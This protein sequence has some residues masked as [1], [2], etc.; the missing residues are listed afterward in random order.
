[1]KFA[2]A[3]IQFGLPLGLAAALLASN[4]LNAA[5]RNWDGDTSTAWATA[6]NWDTAPLNNLTSDIANFNLATYGGNPVYSPSAG[7][8]SIA[9]ISVGS[10]NGNMTITTSALSI[11]ASGITVANGAGTVTIGSTRLGAD[12]SWTNDSSSLLTVTNFSNIGN[13]TPFTV[14]FNGSGSGGTTISGNI[15]DGG[16]TGTTA[17]NINTTGGATTLSGTANAFT[18]G[19]TLTQ[20]TLKLG[21]NAALGGAGNVFTIAGGV[22]DV[23]GA[24][25]TTNNNAQNW[26]GDFIFTGTST[27]NTG[28]G[29][30][31][32]G[33]S[34]QVTVSASTMTVGGAI[35]QAASG[36]TL[37]KL[38]GGT[39]VL[40]GNNSYSGLTTISNGTLTL[41]GNNSGAG[42][43]T[44]SA[45]TL[46]INNAGA[47]GT[48]TFTIGSGTT[49]NSATAIVNSN[50]NAQNWNGSFTFTGTNSL[51]L[52]TGT[53]ALAGPLTVTTTA[54][55][56]TFGGAI[57]GGS[58]FDITKAGAG[59]LAYTGNT[60]M[61]SNRTVN[62]SAGTLAL[63]G[64]IS[65]GFG[66]TVNGAGTLSLSGATANA[67]G[68]AIIINSGNSLTFDSS[69]S[70]VTGTT[71]A[72]SVTLKGATLNVIGNPGASSIDT[73]T[74]ALTATV[75]STFGSFGAST[76]SLTAD[77]AANTR[78]SAGSL[79][80]ANNGAIFFRGINL[81]ANTIASNTAGSS[82]IEFSSA[83]T[84]QLVGGGGAANSQTISI[85]PW[86]VGATT[87]GG[88][89]SS[90]VTYDANGIRPLIVGE[91]ATTITGGTTTSNNIK[92]D[93][94]SLTTN[95]ATL[96]TANGATTVN[97]LF[98]TN[99]TIS[100]QGTSATILAGTGA[101]T[102]TSGA[103]YIDFANGGNNN[104]TVISK[105]VDFGAAEGVIGTLGTSFSKVLSFTGGISGTGG[106]T[107][108]DTNAASSTQAGVSIGAATTYTGNTIINGSLIAANA[109]AL[110]N[111]T[112]GRTGDIYVYG[113]LGVN[114]SVR[115]N[116]L[117]G[118]GRVANP[119]STFRTLTVGDN[120]ATSTF[121][122]TFTTSN[123]NLIKMGT[124]T[125]TLSGTNSSYVGATTIQNG[126]ISVVT[127]NSVSTPSQALTSTLGKPNSSANGTILLGNLTTTGTLKV[128]GTGET[129][130]RIIS[131]AGRTGGGTLDQSGT[132][133]LLF[134]SDVA[135]AGVA[136]TDQRKTL[137]LQGSSLGTGEI[138]GV[139]SDSL[140]G[141]TG[142]KAT[143]LTKS[144]SGT[145]TLS[146][147]NT[148]TG[149]TTV[150]AGK[151]VINGNISTSL[152]TTV[153]N[154]ATLGGN[155]TVG[156]TN[157]ENGGTIA[158][159]SSAG[160]LTLTNG[161]T[162]AGTYD[163]EL[164]TLS[165]A[166]PGTNFDLITLTAGNVDLTGAE[167][168][169]NLGSNAPT[170][171]A[172][173]Q[174]TQTWSGIINNTGAGSL[175]GAF[176]A[177]DNSAWSSLGSFST[178]NSGNDVNLI[179]TAVPEPAP[180]ALLGG[181]GILTLLRRRRGQ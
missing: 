91:Y 60:T 47:L 152:T 161:L 49:I 175:T 90:F 131:L 79:V 174:T 68:S 134:T 179:W 135:A 1:M 171:I 154:T 35:G 111:F 140:L 23:T 21:A 83:P 139:I 114:D 109:N 29:A 84:A 26:N 116:G 42:G 31:T 46:N 106:L 157:V 150:E 87:A 76:V 55:T 40:N 6:G 54:S 89:P 119:F 39:L 110:P 100:G 123:L 13:V 124:G 173:W 16:A 158:P 51:N 38:G 14:T 99:V 176:A 103:I 112:A 37:T 133:H 27:W 151:L 101:L 41:A 53:V 48:G 82:N 8:T 170:N 34:R 167:L 117:Y 50:I 164:A 15:T 96:L 22:I 61:A 75:P 36:Y 58:I 168:G 138:S 97:S 73:I 122:G 115:I 149:A 180:A 178:A 132:G 95:G 71:R 98:L 44:L 127:L 10:S 155:G 64:T 30:I 105:P 130:D 59:T 25:T 19:L 32:L 120:N 125:L 160:E 80:R 113:S 104:T 165:T 24:R 3:K 143:S 136:A 18:G 147:T 163:W 56:L 169:L 7:T 172:F 28:T 66:I 17:V 146:G 148:Y 137:T 57:T 74:G 5:V 121:D 181:F 65:G 43:V 77:P 129:T 108:Y 81:G 4:D 33:G 144:G 94:T 12:Q 72:A 88:N 20:G 153:K 162:L 118:T 156:S 142:Q 126:T 128:V 11:G 52:G 67:A 45:G 159:G 62:V 69:T 93:G 2:S 107:I 63:G 9:G 141:N 92:L 85:L 78:L 145:W 70:G 166:G 86:A 102:V 177:I